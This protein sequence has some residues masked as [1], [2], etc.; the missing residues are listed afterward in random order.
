[1]QPHVHMSAVHGLAALALVIT[2]M[3][4]AH[5]LAISH[6]TRLSRAYLAL[7]F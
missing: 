1:M 3:G 5:L 6:D 2:V 4:T 7:G